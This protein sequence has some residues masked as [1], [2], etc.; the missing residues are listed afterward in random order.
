[1]PPASLYAAFDEEYS[2]FAV[3]RHKKNGTGR[4]KRP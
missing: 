3:G 1:M 2:I 4:K